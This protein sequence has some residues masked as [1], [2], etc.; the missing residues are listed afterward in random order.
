M[1]TRARARPTG[2]TDRAIYVCVNSEKYT[3]VR[4]TP[5]SRHQISYLRLLT[6]APARRR[7][8]ARDAAHIDAPC[9]PRS[10]SP[11]PSRPRP[12]SLEVR[13]VESDALRATRDARRATRDDARATAR[14][15][16]GGA[17][18]AMRGRGRARAARRVARSREED[19][20]FLDDR[21]TARDERTRV[22]RAGGRGR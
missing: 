5:P 11:T 17:R 6:R 13:I 18:A 12:R 3:N 2:A 21:S 16:V 1:R 7:R 22:A 15:A 20:A 19:D 10:R 14:D 4:T 9:T 8:G